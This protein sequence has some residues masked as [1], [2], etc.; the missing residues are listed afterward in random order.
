MIYGH[1]GRN[2]WKGILI[3]DEGIPCD[4]LIFNKPLIYYL[5]SQFLLVGINDITIIG[6]C[7]PP[8]LPGVQIRIKVIG[9][10][11]N[12]IM[13]HDLLPAL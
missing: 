11:G 10:D 5:L 2:E 6:K 3:L 4:T 8:S 7:T 1:E 12:D 13:R 9:K